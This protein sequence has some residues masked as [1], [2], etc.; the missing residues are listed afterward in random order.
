MR[1]KY[2]V[3]ASLNFLSYLVCGAYSYNFDFS[4]LE[5]V[6]EH[7]SIYIE[8]REGGYSALNRV[9][10]LNRLLVAERESKRKI[11][12]LGLCVT[13]LVLK[14]Q[15]ELRGVLHPVARPCQQSFPL[16]LH[17]ASHSEH[18]LESLRVKF[19]LHM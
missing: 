16:F 10:L 1:K 4:A 9:K 12:C 13:K 15:C 17:L 2:R 14:S 18:G 3:F 6:A 5:T 7:V 11:G 19:A 8:I